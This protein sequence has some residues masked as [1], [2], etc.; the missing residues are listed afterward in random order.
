MWLRYQIISVKGGFVDAD[1][2]IVK[3]KLVATSK[4]GKHLDLYEK[5]KAHVRAAGCKI[6]HESIHG[7]TFA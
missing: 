6:M 7:T 2:I 4:D 3:L 1:V 5:A